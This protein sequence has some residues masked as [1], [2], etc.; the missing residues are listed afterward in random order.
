MPDL[1]VDLMGAQLTREGVGSETLG[2]T[3][4]PPS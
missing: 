2:V 3:R 4:S 1:T